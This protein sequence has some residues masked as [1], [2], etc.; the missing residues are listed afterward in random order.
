MHIHRHIHDVRL[1]FN[2][3]GFMNM[4]QN[5]V[6][7]VRFIEIF[8]SVFSM[9][10]IYSSLTPE[11][12][13]FA[14]RQWFTSNSISASGNWST[15]GQMPNY[16][17][18][19][20]NLHYR[21]SLIHTYLQIASEMVTLSLPQSPK[22][23]KLCDYISSGPIPV[24]NESHPRWPPS[25]ADLRLDASTSENWST[26]LFPPLQWCICCWLD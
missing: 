1:D 20:W 21:G 26:M 3:V 8:L 15:T 22:I 16:S 11:D 19:V 7:L 13:G 9:F 14:C 10:R 2:F 24:G 25:T 18:T 12:S 23:F 6:T 17:G 5:S 4:T